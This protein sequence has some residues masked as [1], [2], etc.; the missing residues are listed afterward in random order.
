MITETKSDNSSTTMQFNIEGHYTFRLH[1]NE[2]EGGM[3]LY[4][5]DGIPFKLTPK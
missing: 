2:Y 4:V 1:R 5:R 3:L